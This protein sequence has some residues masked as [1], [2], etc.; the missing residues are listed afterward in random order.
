VNTETV[1]YDDLKATGRLAPGRQVR[2]TAATE[3]PIDHPLDLSDDMFANGEIVAAMATELA[4]RVWERIPGVTGT[5]M[6]MLRVQVEHES[7][8]YLADVGP[9]EPPAP[10]ETFWTPVPFEWTRLNRRG[11]YRLDVDL[12]V[13]ILQP[14]MSNP[15]LR[16]MLDLS[17]TGCRVEAV[18]A[19]PGEILQLRF[20]LMPVA[21]EIVV[22]ARVVRSGKSRGVQWTALEFLDIVPADQDRLV[23]YMLDE[24]RRLLAERLR[25]R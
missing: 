15:V 5:H 8:L 22:R 19:Q 24:Q 6:A 1:R 17:V 4:M 3:E 25:G 21:R 20:G 16:R 11:A 23:R 12:P 14:G 9:V 2:V 7:A 13:L 10:G 18:S